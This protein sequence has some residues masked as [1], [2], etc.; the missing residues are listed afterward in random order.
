MPR[1]GGLAIIAG[2]IVSVVYLILVMTLEKN[3][4]LNPP[5]IKMLLYDTVSEKIKN[6]SPAWGILNVDNLI[7]ML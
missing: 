5:E 1:L 2:F 3:P 7:K 4:D 6:F